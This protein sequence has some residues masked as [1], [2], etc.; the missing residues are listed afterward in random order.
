[1][2]VIKKQWTMTKGHC[3]V[4]SFSTRRRTR[5]HYQKRSISHRTAVKNHQFLVLKMCQISCRIP[6]NTQNPN[7]PNRGSCS[8]PT[9]IHHLLSSFALSSIIISQ[10]PKYW[11]KPD[12]FIPEHFLENGEV[13]EDK[14]GFIPYGVGKRVCPGAALADIQVILL[15]GNNLNHCVADIHC[16]HQPLV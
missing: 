14:P 9:V 4:V 6:T 12:Q 2:R 13:I 11:A 15:L 10:D 3:C 16:S 8:V 5:F 7:L 1:M